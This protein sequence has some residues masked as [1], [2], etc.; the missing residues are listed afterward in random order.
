MTEPKI[1]L[2]ERV[3]AESG[4]YFTADRLIETITSEFQTIEVFATQDFGKLMRIDGCNMV[5][6]RDEFFYHENLIHPVATAHPNPQNVLIIGGGDGGAGEEILKHPSVIKVILC[7]L[8]AAVVKLSKRYFE[9][10]HRSVFDEPKLSLKIGDGTKFVRETNE[11][12]D[13]IT[14][15]LTDPVGEAKALYSQTFF[16]DCK[17]KLAT[18]GALTIHIGSP[19]AHPARVRESMANLR[20]TFRIVNCWFVHIPMYGATWGF[21]CGSDALDIRVISA[22]EIDKR[23][24]ERRVGHRQF[25]NGATHHA[26]QV[27]PEYIYALLR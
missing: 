22:A 2:D 18:G 14:L 7:E 12:F 1:R 19:F 23:L 6:E 21:A 15:D 10:V 5:S 13:L 25:Y 24:A 16:A 3:T 8:D 26:M 17:T 9:S 20:A 4:A 11:L 27:L